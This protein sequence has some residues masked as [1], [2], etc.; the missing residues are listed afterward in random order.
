MCHAPIFAVARHRINVDGKGIVTLVCFGGCPLRCKYCINGQYCFDKESWHD[1]TAEQLFE[2]L[3]SDNLYF[4]ATGGGVT[5]GGGEPLMQAD[6]ILRF[7]ELCGNDWK[8]NVETSLNVPT[9]KLKPLIGIVDNWI[10]DIKDMNPAIYKAYTGVDNRK[11]VEHLM[12]LAEGGKAPQTMVRVPLIKDYNA[13]S[14]RTASVEKLQE[15]GFAF[16]E[17]LEY[18]VN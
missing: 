18:V 10:V 4:L 13:E 17:K 7:R 8:I 1:Y 15:L 16:F 3:Q 11:V 2:E 14:D 12:L 9:E 5:F 6:F